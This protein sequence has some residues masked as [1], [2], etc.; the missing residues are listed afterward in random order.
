[1]LLLP[2]EALLLRILELSESEVFLHIWNWNL[3][4]PQF[5]H[6]MYFGI[7]IQLALPV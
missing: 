1:M 5:R 2:E 3:L 4:Y 6:I 7:F